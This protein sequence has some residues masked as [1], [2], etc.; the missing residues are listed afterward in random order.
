MGRQDHIG[1]GA[2]NCIETLLMHSKCVRKFLHV[3]YIA[4]RIPH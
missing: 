2:I 1:R 4:D 3:Q